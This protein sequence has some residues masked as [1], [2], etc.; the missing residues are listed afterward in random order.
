MV[1][2]KALLI[3]EDIIILK[4]LEKLLQSKAFSCR[5]LSSLSQLNIEDQTVDFDIIITDILFDGIGPMDFITQVQEIILHKSLLVVTSMGQK[6]VKKEILS[7]NGISGFFSVPLDL[8][9][10]E[11][12]LATISWVKN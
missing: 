10:I 8:D 7:L 12:N 2:K 5:A 11:S 1:Q 3:Q 6:K 4:I 9:T